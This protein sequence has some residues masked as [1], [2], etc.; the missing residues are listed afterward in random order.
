MRYR[1]FPVAHTSSP[2]CHS[3][4]SYHCNMAVQESATDFVLEKDSSEQTWFQRTF[5]RIQQ[6]SLRGSI[7]TLTNTALGVSVFL[8]PYMLREAGLI[9]GLAIVALSAFVT[10]LTV[11]I[12]AE[13][14]DD[15]HTYNYQDLVTNL[16]GK[17]CGKVLTVAI[18][19]YELGTITGF[20][21]ISKV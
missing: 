5:S 21:V 2:L 8:L 12:I 18:I 1:Y 9:L 14:A 3:A 20:Q 7:F 11:V 16:L 15:T 19:L 10:H 6:G 13:A 17:V 4:Q